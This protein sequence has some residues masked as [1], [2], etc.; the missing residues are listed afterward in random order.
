MTISSEKPK[1]I[2]SSERK[3]SISQKRNYHGLKQVL[4]LRLRPALRRTTKS[5]NTVD[6]NLK[7]IIKEITCPKGRQKSTTCARE[8]VNQLSVEVARIL[9]S[10]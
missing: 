5:Y 1:S 7:S 6:E 4:S 10:Q 8:E 9:T 3:V 2:A